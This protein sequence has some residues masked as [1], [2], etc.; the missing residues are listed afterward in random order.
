MSAQIWIV[1][2]RIRARY[3]VLNGIR[4]AFACTIYILDAVMCRQVYQV[5][6]SPHFEGALIYASKP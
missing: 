5:A 6:V 1:S 3:L 4:P 2:N